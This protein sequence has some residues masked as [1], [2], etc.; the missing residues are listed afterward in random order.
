MTE[1]EAP[2]YNLIAPKVPSL[3]TE[4]A[5]RLVTITSPDSTCV[6][7]IAVTLASFKD[8]VDDFFT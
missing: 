5:A 8:E 7:D 6:K 1:P 3:T 2:N 4:D